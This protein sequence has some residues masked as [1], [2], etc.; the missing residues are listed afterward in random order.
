MSEKEDVKLTIDQKESI[1]LEKNTKG[2]NWS[3]K[4]LIENKEDNTAFTRLEMLN[5]RLKETYGE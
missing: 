4:I 1:T 3:L 2:Y 5:N